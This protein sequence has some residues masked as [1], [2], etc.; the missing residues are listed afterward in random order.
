MSTAGGTTSAT[1]ATAS[2]SIVLL[3]LRVSWHLRNLAPCF[4]ARCRA[5]FCSHDSSSSRLQRD[6]AHAL[7]ALELP[8]R[9]EVRSAQGY[10]LDVVV[11]YEGCEVA[12]EVDGP[13]HFTTSREPTGAT[14]LKRRQ[15]RAAGWALLPVPY[16]EWD[17]LRRDGRGEYLRRG[18]HGAVACAR[19]EAAPEPTAA[20]PAKAPSEAAA[21]EPAADAAGL[22]A[23]AIGWN[24]FQASLKGQGL[25][26]E[27]VRRRYFEQRMCVRGA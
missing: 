14:Q 19:P 17:E 8:L 6:V 13:S 2:D 16:W 4:A 23:P 15:L 24:A 5:A 10:S 20:G 7:A 21:A 18:L 27:E 12:V 25:S 11:I 1:K 22:M 9:E 3:W 26:R